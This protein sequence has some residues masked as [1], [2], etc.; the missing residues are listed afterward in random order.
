MGSLSLPVSGYVY[1]DT[2]AIIYTVE[3]HPKYSPILR[4]LWA[5][6][7]AG[8][9]TVVTSELAIMEA[10]VGPLRSGD[11]ALAADYDGL[12]DQ[13]GIDLIPMIRPLLRKAAQL[14][15]DIPSLRTPDAIHAVSAQLSGCSLIVTNDPIFRR[16]PGIVT[17][18]LDDVIAAK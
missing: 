4:P 18:V 15:A 1:V 14:R 17:A 2:S 7:Q 5:A 9:I 16:V 12:F 6:A 3:R 13:G 11:A 8:N 10:M